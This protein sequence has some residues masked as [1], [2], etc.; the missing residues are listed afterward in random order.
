MK[1][2]QQVGKIGSTERK[3]DENETSTWTREDLLKTEKFE[4]QRRLS[5][6]K[7]IQKVLVMI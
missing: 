2:G 4:E 6:Q 3:R 5:M 1:G 7:S